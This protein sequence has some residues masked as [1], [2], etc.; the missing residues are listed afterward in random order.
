MILRI[1]DLDAERCKPEYADQIQR[2]YEKLGITWDNTEVMHQRDRAEAYRRAQ[3]KLSD[4]G[5]LYPCYCS[6]AD[7]HAASAPHVGERY[8]YAGTCKNLTE[9][10]R[11]LRSRAR[12]AAMRCS[13]PDR[14]VS[15]PDK[16]QGRFTQNLAHECGDFIIRRSDG[17]YA[18]QLAVVVD[19][20]EQGVNQVVRGVDLMDSTPQQLYLREMLYKGAEPPSY[21]HIPLLVDEQGRRLSKRNHDQTLDGL[22]EV[23]GS[24]EELL[25]YLAGL[26]GVAETKEP[27][28]MEGLLSC[29][30]LDSL[31]QRREIRWVLPS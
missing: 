25:G 21:W 26:T 14:E 1:E 8:L 15:F 4:A 10:E 31:R 23:F 11:Q 12:N 13:V 18:Y 3:E 6:R 28:T 19:D 22:L 2:D 16:L 17:I 30:S 5:L 7:L 29:F 9:E 20:A 27:L 24:V